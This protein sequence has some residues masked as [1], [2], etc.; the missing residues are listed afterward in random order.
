[1]SHFA[2]CTLH[3]VQARGPSADETVHVQGADLAPANVRAHTQ[4]TH[5]IQHKP[6]D[7]KH[8]ACNIRGDPSHSRRRSRAVRRSAAFFSPPKID[9]ARCNTQRRRTMGSFVGTGSRC[10]GTKTT[11]SIQR[12]RH[13]SFNHATCKPPHEGIPM[14]ALR[15]LLIAIRVLIF[16][17]MVPGP[18]AAVGCGGKPARPEAA[19]H[20]G[21]LR[22][23]P[24]CPPAGR[25]AQHRRRDAGMR[26]ATCGKKCDRK[27]DAA[28]HCVRRATARSASGGPL[29]LH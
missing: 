6:C 12:A 2:C 5:T 26:P 20:D 13:L 10:W 3:A 15:A 4:Q 1:M 8:A 23:E 28:L 9:A 18:A 11:C 22:P 27:C 14:I 29:V 24:G 19:A 16:A 17:I 21:Q 7:T 25:A